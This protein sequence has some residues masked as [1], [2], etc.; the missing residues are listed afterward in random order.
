MLNFFMI[1]RRYTGRYLAA[2]FDCAIKALYRN[3]RPLGEHFL[4]SGSQAAIQKMYSTRKDALGFE[5]KW[6]D[7]YIPPQGIAKGP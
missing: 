6:D 7:L 4:Y 5:K 1:N 3:D 2:S